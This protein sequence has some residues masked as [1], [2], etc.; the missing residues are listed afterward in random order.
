[1]ERWLVFLALLASCHSAELGN[2]TCLQQGDRKCMSKTVKCAYD[3]CEPCCTGLQCYHDDDAGDFCIKAHQL[4]SP[5]NAPSLSP[6]KVSWWF[7]VAENITV[8]AMNAATIKAHREVFS[9]VMPY[10]ARI[11]LDGNVSLWW[12]DAQVQQWNGP[13]QAL[14][15]DVLPYLID[16]DNSTQM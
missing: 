6:P 16:V 11:P 2:A 10:N 12:Q 13:L 14:G 7:D 1:M 5:E 9:R 15:V 3:H 4:S 8:D